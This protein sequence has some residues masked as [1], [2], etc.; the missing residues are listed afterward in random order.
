MFTIIV[1][2]LVV[3]YAVAFLGAVI[4]L[5]TSPSFERRVHI[6]HAPVA[7]IQPKAVT[8]IQAMAHHYASSIEEVRSQYEVFYQNHI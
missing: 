3:V 4:T 1:S 7:I 8:D 6:F 5:A 2:L